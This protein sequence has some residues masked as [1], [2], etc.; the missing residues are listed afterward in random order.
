M[1]SVDTHVMFC[2]TIIPT[3][4]RPSLT[5]AVL[6]VLSQSFTA[7]DFEVIVVND[8]GRPL[9]PTDWQQS[10]QVT[11]LNTYKHERSVARNVGAAAAR[12]HYLHFLDDDDW[13]L[14]HAWQHFWQLAQTSHAAWL[15]GRS[16]LVDRQDN[17][18]IQLT[19]NIQGNAFIHTMAGEW[20]PLQASLIR[21]Q[22]FF[23]VGGFHPLLAG[24]EDVDLSRRI[25][26]EADIA[27]TPHLVASIGMGEEN[28]TTDY[29]GHSQYS[30]WAREQILTQSG[31]FARLRDSATSD[32]WYG[33]IMRLY[34]TSTIWNMQH[35]RPFIALSRAAFALLSCLAA[36]RYLPS[37]AFWQ[38]VGKA[39]ESPTFQRGFQE[40][41]KPISHRTA[42]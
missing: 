11:I 38:A 10:P 34:L 22:A 31:V 12:G 21:S 36:I 9:P 27:E 20:F 6:S 15:Y 25:T 19:H 26:L 40:A 28:S 5:R 3:V 1:D 33:R 35:K 39:Y 42:V 23:A 16:Q 8:S 13:L 18:I 7:A 24:P 4:G 41:N 2:S 30:R 32:V 29:Q 17:P 37:P 14:P